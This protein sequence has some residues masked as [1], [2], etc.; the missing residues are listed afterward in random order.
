MTEAASGSGWGGW[1]RTTECRLQRPMPYHLATPQYDTGLHAKRTGP[2]GH[3][4][5]HPQPA[6]RILG[7]LGGLDVR[8]DGLV[9]LRAGAGTGA[10]RAAA[11]LG[12]RGDAGERRL[13]RQRAL[14]AVSGRMG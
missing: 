6:P 1:I 2:A 13:L 11:A 4:R 12:D 7:R 14:R 9:H 10:D 5:A 3:S 8:R